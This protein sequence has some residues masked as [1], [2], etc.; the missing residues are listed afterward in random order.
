[1]TTGVKERRLPGHDRRFEG[2]LAIRNGLNKLLCSDCFNRTSF[3][4]NYWRRNLRS[5]GS[6]LNQNAWLNYMTQHTINTPFIHNQDVNV[7]Q[8]GSRRECT[9]NAGRAPSK[10]FTR[11]E[12]PVCFTAH[13]YHTRSSIKSLS[14]VLAPTLVHH[15]LLTESDPL[16]SDDL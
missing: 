16:T 12:P 2:V 14:L 7:P 4:I 10:L 6:R 3:R 15:Y 8:G 13:S 11:I 1:M 9:H 5:I